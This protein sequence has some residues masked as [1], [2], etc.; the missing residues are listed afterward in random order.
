[1]KHSVGSLST[2]RRSTHPGEDRW[3]GF[4]FTEWR[5]VV[6]A[7]PQ[8]R[9]HCQP[10]LPA[11]L[12]FY[13]LRLTETRGGP[14]CAGSRVGH[15]RL[16]LLPLLVPTVAVFGAALWTRSWPRGKPHPPFCR[17]LAVW[18]IGYLYLPADVR[19]CS[20]TTHRPERDDRYLV[21]RPHRGLGMATEGPAVTI[22][23]SGRVVS[24]SSHVWGSLIHRAESAYADAEPHR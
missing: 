23:R 20:L 16:L 2:S 8:F 24:G 13:D 11:D 6:Q 1:M 7:R 21:D 3:W 15:L 17:N 14:G 4:G 22:R 5:N 10:D 19:L 18:L 12:R 9:G